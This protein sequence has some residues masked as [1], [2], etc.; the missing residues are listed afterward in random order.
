M[1]TI[2]KTPFGEMT[3][4]MSDIHTTELIRIA[5]EYARQC[6]PVEVMP[7]E[8]HQQGVVVNGPAVESVSPVVEIH[9][10]AKPA[11]KSR[12]ETMFGAREGWNMPAADKREAM[13]ERF[14]RDGFTGFLHLV[15]EECGETKTFCTKQ[16]TTAFKCKCGHETPLRDLLP[17][18]VTC[19]CGKTSKYKTNSTKMA[20]TMNCL[21]CGSP[22]DLELNRRGTA[23]V[24]VGQKCFRGGTNDRPYVFRANQR[25]F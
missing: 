17:I 11:P 12:A 3:F 9:E 13:R 15:C 24:P 10:A 19:K 25:R 2:I 6:I 1:K 8:E 7:A 5:A 4:E 23:Y 14:N 22:V 21:D 16:P 18:H 20:F